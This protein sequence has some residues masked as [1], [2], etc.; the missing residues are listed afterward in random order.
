MKKIFTLIF[1]LV[2]F[3][4][5]LCLSATY[6]VDPVNGDDSN[7][8][9]EALAWRS[10][11]KVS[12]ATQQNDAIYLMD[13]AEDWGS[14]IY[15]WPEN[16][17]WYSKK[18]MQFEFAWVFDKYYRIG[19]FVNND[20][21]VADANTVNLIQIDPPSYMDATVDPSRVR[22]GLMINP[23]HPRKQGFD[24][25]AYNF[26]EETNFGMNISPASPLAVQPGSSIISSK[27]HETSNYGSF[28]QSAAVLTVLSS[29][30]PEK[31]FRPSYFGTDK[32][33]RHNL[34]GLDSGKLASLSREGISSV[35]KLKQENRIE[36][37]TASVE[38]MFERPWIDLI[39][40]WTGRNIHPSSNMNEY[41][42]DIS[43]A[44]GI[45]A[46]MLHLDFPAEDKQRHLIRFTQLGL[47]L[48][49]IVAGGS[50]SHWSNAGGHCAGR[51]WPILFAGIV[52][53]DEE[54]KS[55]SKKSGEY[56]Y[57]PKPGGGNYGSGDLPPDYIRFQEDMQTFYVSEKDILPTP[58]I[59][60]TRGSV[61]QAGTV[62]VVQGSDIVEGNN[63]YWAT[64][65]R[66][67]YNFFGI[68]DD[69]QAYDKYGKAYPL[70]E[71]ISNTRLRLAEKY[72]AVS[73]THLT[74]PTKRIV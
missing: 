62:N 19:R 2:C 56:L 34:T 8:G 67:N 5:V 46:L 39:S 52:L 63:T 33:V 71:I 12:S 38:R 30:P 15:D 7:P 45:G 25:Y 1:G 17:I 36:S 42:R 70:A 11:E 22:N 9:T 44:M 26:D 41:G 47:D 31:S 53:N 18:I 69:D 24:S 20:F 21:W 74:L 28:V 6:Y 49:G 50:I 57:S 55:I 43:N 13:F 54:I 40:G 68:V 58:Y 51:K 65:D 59:T 16:R 66:S 60:R 48:Y 32:T 3:A 10:L 23:V 64:L 27:S 72:R 29:V 61:Y 4:R 73:Y 35:P 14:S 37:R